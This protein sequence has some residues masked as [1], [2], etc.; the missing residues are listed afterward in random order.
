MTKKTVRQPPPKKTGKR[1]LTLLTSGKDKASGALNEE[2]DF[3]EPVRKPTAEEPQG[4]IIVDETP[5]PV[6]VKGRIQANFLKPIFT[7]APKSGDRLIALQ[8]VV[9][10]T[11]EHEDGDV[12]PRA[13]KNAWHWVAKDSRTYAAFDVPGQLVKF[14]L[15]HD[16]KDE[17]L[18]LPA[19][20]VESCSIS[21][22]EKKGEGQALKV[23]RWSFRYQ[24]SWSK[25]VERF[26]ASNYGNIY[27]IITKNTE[28]K[29]F[30]EE[31]EEE[32]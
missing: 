24:V 27:W 12:I 5:K 22:V 4:E 20:K 13:V 8:M 2:K 14:Y 16:D 3:D 29:L 28:E 17:A 9:V 30:D 23:I 18:V 7:K 1:G 31:A 21:V 10:L 11:K 25:E 32:E 19:A 15:T 26:A 6:V